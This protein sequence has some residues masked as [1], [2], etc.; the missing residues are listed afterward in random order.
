VEELEQAI[1]SCEAAHQSDASVARQLSEM[2]TSRAVE[3]RTAGR[4]KAG[5]QGVKAQTALLVLAD[6]SVFL[7]PP[8]TEISCKLRAGPGCACTG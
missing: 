8:A 7:D 4:L 6:S 2:G 5:L 3:H 1:A